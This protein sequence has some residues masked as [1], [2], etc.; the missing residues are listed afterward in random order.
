E[1]SSDRCRPLIQ[2]LFYPTNEVVGERLD[3]LGLL[4]RTRRRDVARG[5]TTGDGVQKTDGV[6][7]TRATGDFPGANDRGVVGGVR[8]FCD[9][10]HV[11][12]Q[13]G[14]SADAARVE[15]IEA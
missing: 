4:R 7:T 5:F 8:E 1:S 12:V 2:V 15:D 10:A 6:T 13:L 9:V 11:P 3:L 14:R